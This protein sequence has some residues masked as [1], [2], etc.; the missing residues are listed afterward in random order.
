MRKTTVISLFGGPGAG[1]STLA[2]ALFA[3]MKESNVNCEMVR[4]YVKTWAWQDREIKST[5][6][7]YVLAK[8]C[9]AESILYNKV[10][11][12][13]TDCPI[14]LPGVYQR[15]YH[16][17][18]YIGDAGIGV[19]RDAKLKNVHYKNYLLSRGKHFE[20]EGRYHSKEESLKIDQEIPKLLQYYEERYKMLILADTETL[21]GKILKDLYE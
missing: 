3:K 9:Q 20:T 17:G 19:I 21:V 16:G 8:Q 5:D 11:Y 1:K 12:V 18:T 2:A 7:I 13:I 14:L 4:E 15:L 10:D 6:Q